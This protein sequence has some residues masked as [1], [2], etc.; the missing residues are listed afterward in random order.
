VRDPELRLAALTEVADAA[1]GLGLTVCGAVASPLPGPSGNVE[2][3]LWLRHGP[4]TVDVDEITSVVH[5][6]IGP[7][8]S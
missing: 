8:P 4:A 2:F 6:G 5:R 3:F 7:E 1:R